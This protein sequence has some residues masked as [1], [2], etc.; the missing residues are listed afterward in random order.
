M[1][2][3]HSQMR[4]RRAGQRQGGFTLIELLVVIAIL[5]ILAAIV[6]FSVGGITDRGDKSAC[7]STSKTVATAS[8][9]YRAKNTGYAGSL[10]ALSEF[11]RDVPASGNSITTT[12]GTVTY[13]P[14]TGAVT[15]TCA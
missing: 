8:E 12:G 6:V 13:T 5:G 3:L 7:D 14:S 2:H 10:Q 1:H 11:V 9:A 15:D 4:A